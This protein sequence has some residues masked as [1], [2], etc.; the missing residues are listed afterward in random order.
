L[1]D[2]PIPS[3]DDATKSI[4][5]IL[6]VVCGAIKEGLEERKSSKDA[7]SDKEEEEVVVKTE[8]AVEEDEVS[9]KKATKK[10]PVVKKVKK[11]AE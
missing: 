5:A 4:S 10:A 1:V 3:N 9:V 6:D 11:D 8:V 2:F 7:A